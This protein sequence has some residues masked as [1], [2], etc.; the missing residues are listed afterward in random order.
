MANEEAP[1]C[2]MPMALIYD[3]EITKSD[4]KVFGYI[5][6]RCGKQGT[7]YMPID[8]IVAD[9]HLSEKM[10][11]LAIAKLKRKGYITT[12]RLGRAQHFKLQFGIVARTQTPEEDPP[13]VFGNGLPNSENQSGNQLP[14]RGNQRGNGLPNRS[15][16]ETVFGNPLPEGPVMDYRIINIETNTET[17][18]TLGN[19]PSEGDDREG[20]KAA[21]AP[22]EKKPRAPN[23]Y[24]DALVE[25]IGHPAP[26]GQNTNWGRSIIQLKAM[27]ATPPEIVRRCEVYR[28]LF[29]G[30]TLTPNALVKLWYDCEHMPLPSKQNGSL[31]VVAPA[32]RMP[33]ATGPIRPTH[34]KETGS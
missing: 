11:R 29:P 18:D 17:K 12:K 23:P 4:L 34:A 28:V 2:K 1:W 20:G 33:I 21:S 22:T 8:E 15:K 10:I 24:W 14:N 9:V 27:A 31:R 16:K 7:W 3:E 19:S 5:D 6:H 13:P 30:R 32:R 25:G 26:E